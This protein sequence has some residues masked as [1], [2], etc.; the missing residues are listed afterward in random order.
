MKTCVGMLSRSS[1]PLGCEKVCT[2]F[3]ERLGYSPMTFLLLGYWY[4]VLY[5]SVCMYAHMSLCILRSVYI[6]FF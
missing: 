5:E 2:E 4:L 6:K 3:C 1:Y